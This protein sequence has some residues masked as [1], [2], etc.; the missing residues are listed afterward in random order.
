MSRPQRAERIDYH[1]LNDGSD[2]ESD[3]S[4]RLPK[5]ARTNDFESVH[6]NDSAS[7]IQPPTPMITP[8]ITPPPPSES[9]A[10][11]PKVQK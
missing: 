4:D 11:R 6:P 1:T 10:S 7:Q 5:R 2:E 8:I 3:A 9:S